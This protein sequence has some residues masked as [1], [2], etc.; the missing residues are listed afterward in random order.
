MMF[1][2]NIISKNVYPKIEGYVNECLINIIKESGPQIIMEIGTLH[3][4]TA[5]RLCD[6]DCEVHSFDIAKGAPFGWPEDFNIDRISKFEKLK[7]KYPKFHFYP[8]SNKVYDSYNWSL[9]KMIEKGGYERYFDI[10]FSDGAHVYL[11]DTLA[12]FLSDIMLKNGGIMIFDDYNWILGHEKFTEIKNHYTKEQ[13]NTAHVKFFIETV[14]AKHANYH[15]L[16]RETFVK[17]P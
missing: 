3:M 12:F 5:K 14:V 6:L 11:H 17:K 4:N 2:L 13:L 1:D 16:G 8:N 10:I 9:M 15:R 7:E